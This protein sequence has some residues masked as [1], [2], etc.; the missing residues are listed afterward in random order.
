MKKPLRRYRMRTDQG[1]WVAEPS[2]ASPVYYGPE[3]GQG[4][5]PIV[6]EADDDEKG[7]AVVLEDEHGRLV[8][9]RG[10]CDFCGK[11]ADVVVSEPGEGLIPA[12]LPASICAPCATRVLQIHLAVVEN[13]DG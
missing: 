4:V 10:T 5:A 7:A 6:D 11:E 8:H 12:P 2:L 1:R 3:P 9:E 13:A